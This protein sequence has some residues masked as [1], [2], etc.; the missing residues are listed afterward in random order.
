MYRMKIN[1]I[2]D[3]KWIL[4]QM[5]GEKN[6]KKENKKNNKYNKRHLPLKNRK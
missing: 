5:G 6:V 2:K 4:P 1:I 3:N